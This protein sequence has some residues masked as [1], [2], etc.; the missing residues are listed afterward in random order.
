MISYPSQR[1]NVL[2]R[3][4]LQRNPAGISVDRVYCA[5][6]S[7][8]PIAEVS[9]V[10]IFCSLDDLMCHLNEVQFKFNGVL[11]GVFTFSSSE[12]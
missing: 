8:Y 9:C 7:A 1:A 4:G 11:G 12:G 2:I 10:T 5:W 3:Q 6:E